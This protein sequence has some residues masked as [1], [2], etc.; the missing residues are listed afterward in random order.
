MSST[1]MTARRGIMLTIM[2]G[3]RSCWWKI[4]RPMIIT[5]T[6]LRSGIPTT[7]QNW[8][9]LAMIE[10]FLMS[11]SEGFNEIGRRARSRFIPRSEVLPFLEDRHKI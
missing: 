6:R 10:M 3:R 1:V 5:I 7:L 9:K 2:E 8:V 11:G 4:Y